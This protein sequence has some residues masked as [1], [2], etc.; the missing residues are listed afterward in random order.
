MASSELR[1]LLVAYD[2]LLT[3]AR[4]RRKRPWELGT[5]T[6]VGE[7]VRAVLSAVER[8]HARRAAIA[9]RLDDA[10][11]EDLE[12]I[13]QFT[14]S[15]PRAPLAAGRLA[16]GVAIIVLAQVLS[17]L[18]GRLQSLYPEARIGTTGPRSELLDALSEVAN[19]SVSNVI[20][21]GR[22][23][24]DTGFAGVAVV[25]TIAGLAAWCVLHPFANG[26]VAGRALRDAD[27]DLRGLELAVLR[28]ANAEPPNPATLDLWV[29]A[30]VAV[31]GVL[32]GLSLTR[33]Y[34]R[35][36]E[37]ENHLFGSA[38]TVEYLQPEGLLLLALV[39]AYLS[40]VRL[41]VLGR[42]Y[43]RRGA[44]ERRANA[45]R[46]A[47]WGR[48]KR[49]FASGFWLAA[50][51]V[52]APVLAWAIFGVRDIKPAG[53][54]LRITSSTDQAIAHRRVNV[55]AD[56]TEEAGIETAT[57]Y[58]V[59]GFRQ[60]TAPERGELDV[61]ELDGTTPEHSIVTLGLTESQRRWMQTK[62]KSAG[63]LVDIRM[64]DVGANQ[65]PLSIFLTGN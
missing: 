28:A 7:H 55:K 35:G 5:Q 13:A 37:D 23:V 29:P 11:S 48:W 1:S 34:F 36:I 53:V 50:V 52:L 45:G 60:E 49:R 54:E 8:S 61:D 6:S 46:H 33:E 17:A 64:R 31:P 30:L 3:R 4:E 43:V 21:V 40:A 2:D 51:P 56:F 22:V 58:G 19:L 26:V 57:L 32:M 12:R 15:L 16:L 10:R 44:P 25:L 41:A 20:K 38:A 9:E 59:E 18:V 39:L 24:L 62:R 27:A 47:D 14:R 65:T 63:F 42:R